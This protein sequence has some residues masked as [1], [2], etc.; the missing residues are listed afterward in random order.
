MIEYPEAV[1]IARQL[2]AELTGKRITFCMRGNSP[3]KFAFYSY[4]PEHYTR[5]MTGAQLGETQVDGMH[6][7]I[8]VGAEHSLVLGGGGEKILLHASEAEIPKKH[9]LLLGFDDGRW[10]SVSVQGWGAVLLL[11]PDELAAHPYVGK[12]H[13]DPLSPD[14]TPAYFHSLFAALNPEEKRS[15]KFFMISDPQVHGVGNGC[16]QDILFRAGIHPRRRAVQISQPEQERLRKA[17]LETLSAAVESG[18]RDSET[19]LY[20]QPGRYV[21]LMDRRSK[22]QPCPQCAAPI[23]KEAYLGGSVYFCPRC[24]S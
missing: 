18:G 10:L 15:A 24:Q 4:P 16:L 11:T 2:G 9:Q 7:L 21:A 8:Q 23:V 13:V 22:D 3:H 17:I 12:P 20:G 5:L 19:D 6:A 14:F 1:T